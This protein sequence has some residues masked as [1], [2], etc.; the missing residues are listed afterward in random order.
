MN[1][2]LKL[3]G[4][5][6]MALLAVSAIGTAG[7]QAATFTSEA[8]AT[9][10]VSTHDGTGKTAHAVIDAAGANLT[11]AQQV[12][13]SSWV[14]QALAGI[15]VFVG[16]SACNSVGQTATVNMNE[17]SLE[18]KAG[19]TMDIV[20]P[21]G[22]EITY[23][24]PNPVCDV[25]IPAQSNKGTLTYTNI[26]TGTSKEITVSPNLT[27]LKYTATGAGCPETGTFTNGAFTTGNYFLTGQDH[28]GKTINIAIVP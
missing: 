22:K 15:R 20:C 1:R 14:G 13:N 19:G 7:V 2:N 10:V 16:L 8:G 18:L 24:T 5:A 4:L 11:C 17:C 23:S 28:A 6:A 27:E 26:T 3:L 25:T 12:A 9:T 21:A